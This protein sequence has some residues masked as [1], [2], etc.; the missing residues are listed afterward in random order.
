MTIEPS[1]RIRYAH[2]SMDGYAESG[3][4]ADLSIPDRDVSLW[5]GRFQVA[6]PQYKQWPNGRIY[7]I[8]P[9]IGFEGRTSN[10]DNFLANGF[11]PINLGGTDND[12]TGF[13]GLTA[14]SNLSPYSKLFVD[15]ELHVGDGGFAHADAKAGVKFKF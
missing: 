8:A 3:S 12:F 5:Q 1:A 10:N 2:L 13:A 4:I 11:I 15:A 9:R 6:F 14:S 7:H